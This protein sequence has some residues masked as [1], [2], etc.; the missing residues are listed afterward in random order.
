MGG[1]ERISGQVKR[2]DGY[3]DLI[4]QMALKSPLR[5]FDMKSK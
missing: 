2:N 1:A 4:Q 5:G 3:A